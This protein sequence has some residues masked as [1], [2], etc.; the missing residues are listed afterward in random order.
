[1]RQSRQAIWLQH[2][3]NSEIL[4]GF[5]QLRT[6]AT[7][8]CACKILCPK[9]VANPAQERN[10]S[11]FETGQARL[12]ISRHLPIFLPNSIRLPAFCHGFSI[13]VAVPRASKQNLVQPREKGGNPGQEPGR[14]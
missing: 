11:P 1:M 10:S 6:I 13:L 12:A 3:G 8:S 2:D 4:A 5:P 9:P 7:A 14:G